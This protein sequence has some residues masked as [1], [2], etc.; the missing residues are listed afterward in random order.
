MAFAGDQ[1]QSNQPFG[2][3]EIEGV[4]QLCKTLATAIRQRTLAACQRCDGS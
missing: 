1:Q 2:D 3:L 4:S